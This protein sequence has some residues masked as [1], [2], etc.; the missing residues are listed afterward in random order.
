VAEFVERRSTLELLKSYGVDMVQGFLVGKPN[1]K[2][3]KSKG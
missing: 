3:P 2:I 1:A